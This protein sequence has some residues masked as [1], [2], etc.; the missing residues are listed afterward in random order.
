MYIIFLVR[1]FLTWLKRL[2]YILKFQSKNRS[3]IHSSSFI[4]YDNLEDIIV[5]RNFTVGYNN[6]ILCTNEHA[7]SL[8]PRSAIVIGN[9]VSIGEFNN[10]R[11]SGGTLKI[12]DNSLISQYVNIIC[13]NHSIALDKPIRDQAWDIRKTGVT[14]GNDVWIGCGVTILPGVSIGNGAIVAAG[15]VVTK[16]VMNYTIVSG[17]PAKFLKNRN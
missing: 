6:L 14:I 7:K 16:D 13:S 8:N 1:H 4:K 15:S 10:I 11:A 3:Y 5:G 9:N 2:Y 12:G 17:I